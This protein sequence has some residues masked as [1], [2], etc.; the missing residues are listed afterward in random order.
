MQ[1]IPVESYV[2]HAGYNIDTKENDIALIR[3]TTDADTEQGITILY[4]IK[5]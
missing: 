3:L 2:M 1:T 5:L 4:R